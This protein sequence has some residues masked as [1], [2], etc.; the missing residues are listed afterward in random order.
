MSVITK[1][2]VLEPTTTPGLAARSIAA[3]SAT[4]AGSTSGED[5]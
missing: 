2:D 1:P 5:S 3:S 4:L